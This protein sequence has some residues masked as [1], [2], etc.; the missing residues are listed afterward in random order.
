MLLPTV[1][2]S[3]PT[4]A[5]AQVGALVAS[6][7]APAEA[8]VGICEWASSHGALGLSAFAA[9]HAAAVVVCFP[10]TILFELAAGF[11]FGVFEGAA[12]AWAAKVVA[13]MITF[14]ASSGVARTALS[15]AA[16]ASTE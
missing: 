4:L 9:T 8:I 3:A 2:S 12:L 10:G 5:S 15:K 1:A 13:A 14:V 16:T 6:A 11:A 7:S